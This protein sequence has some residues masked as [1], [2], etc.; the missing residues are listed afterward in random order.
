V[1]PTIIKLKLKTM[2]HKLATFITDKNTCN[3]KLKIILLLTHIWINC[4]HNYFN[5]LIKVSTITIAVCPSIT[6][7]PHS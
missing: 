3:F 6:P 4:L 1:I 2:C 7:E 5:N